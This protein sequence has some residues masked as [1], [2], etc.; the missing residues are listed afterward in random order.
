[1]S[2]L[3]DIRQRAE[4]ATEGPWRLWRDRSPHDPD[5][6]RGAAVESAW[7]YDADG[8][9]TELITDWCRTADA[10]FIAHA[11]TDIPRLLAALDAA[12]AVADVAQTRAA[13]NLAEGKRRYETGDQDASA[14]QAL[15]LC[16]IQVAH[17]IRAAVNDALEAD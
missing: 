7:A 10:E 13:S 9:D 15:G 16:Q 2:A 11:R 1:M 3:D 4:A 8:E 14:F 17:E 5:N 12:L 6:N